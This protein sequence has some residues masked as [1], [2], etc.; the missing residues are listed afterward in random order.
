VGI[1]ILFFGIFYWAVW[2]IVLPKLGKY[3]LVPEKETLE[4]GTV[5]MTVRFNLHTF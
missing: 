2:R 5:I 1:G 3:T 4:D